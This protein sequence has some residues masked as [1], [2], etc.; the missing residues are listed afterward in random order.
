M[1]KKVLKQFFQDRKYYLFLSLIFL[2]IIARFMLV[3]R[4]PPGI[5]HDE[6]DVIL[7]AKTHWK[8]GKDLSGVSFPESLIFTE[9]KAGLSGLPSFILSSFIGVSEMNLLNARLP[10]ILLGFIIVYFIAAIVWMITSD[11]K[12]TLI[13]VFI[14]LLN[15]WLF[16]YSRSTTE[17]PFALLFSLI[18]IYFFYKNK[19]KLIFVSTASFILAFFSYYGAKPVIPILVS[20]LYLSRIFSKNY[21]IRNTLIINLV[22]FF[23]VVGGF[24]VLL[25][26]NINSTFVSRSPELIFSR[27]SDFGVIVDEQRRA[28]IEFPL[29][30]LVWNKPVQLVVEFSKK[31]FGWISFDFLFFS[32][33]PRA[34]YRFGDHGLF[35]ILDSIFIIVGF[36]AYGKTKE[37]NNVDLKKFR[38][39]VLLLLLVGPIGAAL[40]KIDNSYVFRGFLLIPAL[41][42]TISLGVYKLS[43][44]LRYK[45]TFVII[46][47]V[48][49]ALFINFI[50]FFNFRYSVKQQENQFLS[51]RVLANYLI[52]NNF[53][54]PVTVYVKLPL[55]IYNGFIFFSNN[56]SEEV[57]IGQ[58]DEIAYQYKN[59]TFTNKCDINSEKGLFIVED[60]YCDYD[61]TN[62]LVIQDQKDSGSIF[63]IYNDILCQDKNLTPYRREHF[64]E[65]YLIED[66]DRSAFCER[67]INKYEK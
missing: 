22:L 7:S 57:V 1:L 45:K 55:M 24:F 39:L 46:A 16:F 15:P 19:K 34:T 37:I 14:S 6:L 54:I 64:I 62:F 52:K 60:G 27:W 21:Q 47:V 49:I 12:L 65:D 13:S 42:F 40:T 53:E 58:K 2:G 56:I 29:K 28:S 20:I 31:Y 43:G 35:L 9:T 32:G 25:L 23:L 10:F 5:N 59:Y 3:D 51:E 36:I 26:G 66:M 63:K 61:N 11:K 4:F 48:Y 44:L 17:A 41:I 18:G 8:Y 67:W 50:V 38:N 30:N 33:D